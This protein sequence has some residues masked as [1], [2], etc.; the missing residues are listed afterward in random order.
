MLDDVSLDVAPGEFVALMG[1][2]GC[3]KSTLLRLLAG[4]DAPSDGRRIVVDGDL[5]QGTRSSRVV[6]FSGPDALSWRTVRANASLG[7][8]ARG[9]LRREKQRVEDALKLVGST[10]SR[11]LPRTTFEAGWRKRAALAAPSSK[12]RASSFSMSR[13]ASSTRSRA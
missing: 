10:A 1:P 11:V 2:S 3:G 6:V 9:L 5:V 7:L 13:S 12:S 4:L 8:E